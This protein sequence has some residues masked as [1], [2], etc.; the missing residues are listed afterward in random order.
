MPYQK[1]D[2][3]RKATGVVWA[4]VWA[5]ADDLWAERQLSVEVKLTPPAG[6]ASAPHGSLQV[7]V[8]AHVQGVGFVPRALK[9]AAIPDPIKAST[10]SVALRLLLDIMR[11]Y[12][13]SVEAQATANKEAV[14]RLW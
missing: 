9:W 7:Q 5:W 13:P 12:P 2:W 3:K 1:Y 10:A 8:S 14:D 11:E 4:D 6:A